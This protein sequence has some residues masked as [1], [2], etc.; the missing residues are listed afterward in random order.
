MKTIIFSQMSLCG[1]TKIYRIPLFKQN[2]SEMIHTEIM[3]R[4]L[5]RRTKAKEKKMLHAK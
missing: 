2:Y 1:M 3:V 4:K 5:S